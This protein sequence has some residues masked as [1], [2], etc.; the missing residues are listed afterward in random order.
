M[1]FKYDGTVEY[2]FTDEQ[3]KEYSSNLI[4][5]GTAWSMIG[6]DINQDDIINQTDYD[7]VNKDAVTQIPGSASGF[8]GTDI[9]CD[10]VTDAADQAIVENNF[11]FT[12]VE[13]PPCP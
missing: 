9:N 13:I 12:P 6:G 10:G 3:T 11:S 1:I 5:N 2:D 8:S 4:Y 7:A